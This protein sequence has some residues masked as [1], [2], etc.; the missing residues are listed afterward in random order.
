MAAEAAATIGHINIGDFIPYLDWMDLQGVKQRMKKV[1]ESFD[2][3]VSK[4]VEEHQQRKAKFQEE[5]EQ[6]SDT[7]DIIHGMYLTGIETTTTTLDWAMSEIIKHHRVAKKMR[8]EIDSVVGTE[9][10]VSERDIA[11]MEY[12]Q[13]VV[14][15]TLRLYPAAPFM[16]PH[17]STQDCTI[18]GYFIPKRT[19]L[20][21]N[22]WAIGRDP[23]LW[24][25]PLDFRPERFL[26]KNID[27]VR[28]REYFDML[29]FGAGRRGC[30]GVP[31][32]SVTVIVIDVNTYSSGDPWLC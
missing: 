7:K 23:S 14:K 31:M 30:L 2:Q 15:E 32:A 28:D 21:I 20:M 26:G 6:D 12:M 3:V 11:S 8:E 19:R 9:R 27:F 17:E 25:D 1:H 13:C 10:V 18:G 16:L 24:E 29:P 4:I 22:A 5:Q